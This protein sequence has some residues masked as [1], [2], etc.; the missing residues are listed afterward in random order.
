MTLCPAPQETMSASPFGRKAMWVRL[1]A[2]ALAVA[3][4][5]GIIATGTA[6]PAHADDLLQTIKKKGEIVIASEARYAPFEFV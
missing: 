3:G 4:L 2:C 6:T 1:N 5:A